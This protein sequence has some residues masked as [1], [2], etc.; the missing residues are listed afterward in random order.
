MPGARITEQVSE[1]RFKGAV[2][3][4]IGPAALLLHGD[5]EL[6]ALDPST[7]T[8]KMLGKGMDPSGSSAQVVLEARIEPDPA[9]PT[10]STLVGQATI[11]VD[12]MLVQFGSRLLVPLSDA[13]LAQFGDNFRAAAAATP[14][15][16]IAAASAPPRARTTAPT[17]VHREL[18]ALSLL[19]TA[20]KPQV[21][22]LF[23]RRR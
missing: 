18:N 11:S 1:T 22:G 12:G 8:L 10:G 7:R 4:K 17:P 6:L 9:Q 16:S 21:A 5:I 23:G 2:R 20:I 3:C 13:I 15:S 19:W 14:A